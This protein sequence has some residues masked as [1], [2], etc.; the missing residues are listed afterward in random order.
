ME[1]CHFGVLH[2]E[3]N[4]RASFQKDFDNLQ[5]FLLGHSRSASDFVVSMEAMLADSENWNRSVLVL[6]VNVHRDVV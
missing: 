4:V 1:T 6:T 2:L 5:A 3:V